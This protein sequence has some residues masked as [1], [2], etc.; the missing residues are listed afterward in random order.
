MI[1]VVIMFFIVLFKVTIGFGPCLAYAWYIY[2]Y[3]AHGASAI[4]GWIPCIAWVLFL[5][6]RYSPNTDHI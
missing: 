6:H 2:T 1:V 4:L 3:H 5:D